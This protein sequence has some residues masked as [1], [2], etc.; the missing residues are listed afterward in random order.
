MLLDSDSARAAA[1][2]GTT[3]RAAPGREL[4]RAA[5]LQEV[6]TRV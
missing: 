6:S 3:L 5:M 4:A 2:L 1:D